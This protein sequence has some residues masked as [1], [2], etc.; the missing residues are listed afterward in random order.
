[1]D[2]G[3]SVA[4]SAAKADVGSARPSLSNWGFSERWSGRGTE[5]MRFWMPAL[6]GI[7]VPEGAI[8]ERVPPALGLDIMVVFV[9]L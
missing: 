3:R 8:S 7:V 1:M 9:A 4:L 6:L 5:G 2:R